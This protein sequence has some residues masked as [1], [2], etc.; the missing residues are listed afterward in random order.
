MQSAITLNLKSE[1][2]RDLLMQLV[3]G[4]DVLVQNY[5]GDSLEALGLGYDAVSAV[6][7]RLI[8]CSMSGFAAQRPKANHPADDIVVQAY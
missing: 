4:A 7:P 3:Q 5:S 1:A 2:G 8:Y 6:N